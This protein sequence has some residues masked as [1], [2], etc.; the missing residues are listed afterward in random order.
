K[1]GDAQSAHLH[2]LLGFMKRSLH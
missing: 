2:I 1:N